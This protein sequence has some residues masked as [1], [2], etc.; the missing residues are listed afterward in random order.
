MSK[1]R[2]LILKNCAYCSEEY[3]GRK[4]TQYCSRRCGALGRPA[5]PANT[6]SFKVGQ[7][8]WNAGQAVSGMSGKRHAPETK[9]KMR[10]SSSGHL[11][12]NWKGGVTDENY[13]IRRSRKYADWRAAVFIRDN[14][15]CQECGARSAAGCRVIL[16]ADHI[17]PFAFYPDLRFD[18]DNGRT[19]CE[20]C[21]RATP[22]WGAKSDLTGQ[23]ATLEGDGRTFNEIAAHREAA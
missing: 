15:S 10:N 12:S 18:V 5:R 1:Q 7:T 3:L 17:K 23:D 8:P 13:R 11:G 4:R 22:T 20:P 14:Y 19:L 16:N 6:G 21:H 2:G 9:E